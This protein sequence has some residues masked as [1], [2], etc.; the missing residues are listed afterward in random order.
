MH[1]CPTRKPGESGIAMILVLGAV[2]VLTALVAGFSYSMKVEARLAQNYQSDAEMQWMARSGVELARYILSQE[3]QAPGGRNFDA[4]NQKWAGGVGSFTN[5]ALAGISLTDNIIG[6]GRFSI[7]ITDQERRFNI[8][9]ADRFVLQQA[10]MMMNVDASLQGTLVDS[11]MDWKDPD[12]DPGINGAESDDFYL[13]LTP[14]YYAKNGPIDDISELLLVKGMSPEVYWGS[15]STNVARSENAPRPGEVGRFGESAYIHVGLS[16]LFTAVSAPQVNINTCTAETLQVAGLDPMIAQFVLEAR[17]GPDGA[18]GTEDDMPFLNP[19][20]IPIPTDDPTI[21]QQIQQYF[22]V[23]SLTFEVIVTC[24]VGGY[25]RQFRSLL[26]RRS[27]RD[28]SILFLH[29]I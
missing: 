19:G 28:I 13:R 26:L 27:P 2:I 3:M 23:R 29:G 4:L 7:K 9:A 11:I 5:D 18:D 15:S 25:R 8:N 1:L 12:N 21:R 16:E 6:R 10:L 20:Q 17:R 22:T 24:E 14:P